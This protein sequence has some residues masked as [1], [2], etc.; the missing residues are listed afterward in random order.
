MMAA[1][2][3]RHLSPSANL[4]ACSQRQGGP[5]AKVVQDLLSILTYFGVASALVT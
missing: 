2:T 1:W 4:E 3:K 5:L